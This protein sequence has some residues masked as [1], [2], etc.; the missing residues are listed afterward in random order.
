VKNTLAVVQSLAARSIVDG[1]SSED[2]RKVFTERLAALAHAH[3]LLIE[4]SWRG[5]TIGNLLAA[6]SR[7][8]S[9]RIRA[10]GP[11][12][13]LKPRAVQTFALLLHEL[14]TNSSKHGS[15]SSPTGFVEVRW[16]LDEGREQ[17]RFSWK[18]YGG[19][20]VGTPAHKGFGLTLIERIPRH[21]FGSAPVMQFG[22][23]G[24]S[25]ELDVAASAILA[26][27]SDEKPE[28]M[29]PPPGLI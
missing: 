19:P 22:R 25:F 16:L 24:F 4:F 11:E 6:E 15:L 29:L 2:A 14:A 5:A 9:D 18:E 20:S 12:L 27:P 13:F 23:S 26:S 3:D 7:A 8:F 21:D 28:P 17:F 10:A 1:R